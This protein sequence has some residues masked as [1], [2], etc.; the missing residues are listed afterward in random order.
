MKL[1]SS[2]LLKAP[3]ERVF[4]ALT[5]PEVLR[6][7]IDG[8]EKLERTGEDL[9]EARVRIGLAMIRGT[10]TGQVRISEKKPPDSLTLVLEGKGSPGFV[11]GTAKIELGA[12]GEETELRSESD[13]AVG[14]LIAAVGSRLVEGAAKKIMDEFFARFRAQIEVQQK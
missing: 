11:R 6:R 8:C 9:Y 5:D 12:R 2:H 3:R 14:G 10:F 13:T 1:T 7:C 4:A